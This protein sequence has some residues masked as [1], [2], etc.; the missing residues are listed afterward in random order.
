MNILAAAGRGFSPPPQP[1]TQ[2]MDQSQCFPSHNFTSCSRF[3]H[4]TRA[5]TVT[6]FCLIC[7]GGIRRG[8]QWWAAVGTLTLIGLKLGSVVHVDALMWKTIS[9]CLMKVVP[10]CT[11][12]LLHTFIT[13]PVRSTDRRRKEESTIVWSRSSV[14]T[15]NA[16][17]WPPQQHRMSKANTTF[18]NQS[19]DLFPQYIHGYY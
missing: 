11:W 7:P 2:L 1:P 4:C 13:L 9:C 5:Q 3:L 16:L 14:S 8:W 10:H 15:G 17:L 19:A 12:Y 6:P 18:C